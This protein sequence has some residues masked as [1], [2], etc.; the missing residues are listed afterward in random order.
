MNLQQTFIGNLKRIRKAVGFSQMKLAERCNTAGS[1]IGAIEIGK[2]FPSLKM[3]EQLASALQ[4]KPHLF[5]FNEQALTEEIPEA[6]KEDIIQ[7]LLQITQ[8]IYK[9]NV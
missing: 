5:F 9:S 3:I 6:L 8:K 2:K 1:Y 7:Q 4:I